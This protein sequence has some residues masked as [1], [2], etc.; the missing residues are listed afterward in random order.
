M[1]RINVRNKWISLRGGSY[2]TDENEQHILYV[3]GKFFTITNKKFVQDL[4]GNTLYTVRN[5]FWQFITH[6]GL[7]FDKDGNEVARLRAKIFTLHDHYDIKTP[8]GLMVLRGNILGYDYHFSIDGV[9]VGHV[10]RHISLRDSFFIDI[11]ETKIDV[12]FM[13][14]L[15]I[16]LDVITDQKRA[17]SY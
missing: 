17:E 11:D 3:K 4:E 6:Y 2:V 10:G 8:Y 14:A 12:A 13:V 15:V 1:K 9:E 5:K 7:V 16:A